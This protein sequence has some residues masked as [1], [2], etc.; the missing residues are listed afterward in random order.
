LIEFKDFVLSLIGMVTAQGQ[1][2][3]IPIVIRML[4]DF[5]PAT[6]DIRGLIHYDAGFRATLDAGENRILNSYDLQWWTGPKPKDLQVEVFNR[7]NLQR[8]MDHYRKQQADPGSQ[9][10]NLPAGAGTRRFEG[11]QGSGSVSRPGP[12]SGTHTSDV[13]ESES[14]FKAGHESACRNCGTY[15][16]LLSDV[17]QDVIKFQNFASVL[18]TTS[19]N[20]L[21]IGIRRASTFNLLHEA[22]ILK[23]TASTTPPAKDTK[24]KRIAAVLLNAS[25]ELKRLSDL[26]AS[27]YKW[28][29]G[30][31]LT[32]K[33]VLELRRT[34]TSPGEVAHSGYDISLPEGRQVGKDSAGPGTNLSSIGEVEDL[35]AEASMSPPF[36]DLRLPKYFKKKDYR[37]AYN[38]FQFLPSSSSAVLRT[39]SSSHDMGPDPENLTGNDPVESTEPIEAAPVHPDFQTILALADMWEEEDRVQSPGIEPGSIEFASERQGAGEQASESPGNGPVESAGIEPGSVAATLH[40]DFQTILT[41]AEMWETEEGESP[42]IKPGSVEF[43]SERRGA[44]E[45]T[46]ESPGN[47]PVESTGIAPGIVE[48][49]PLHPDF[50]TILAL[51]DMWETEEGDRVQS[52]GIEPG[53]IDFT[54]ER[55]GAGDQASESPGGPVV[56]TGIEPGSIEAAPLHPDFQ[57]ILALADMWETEEG[58]PVQSP[59]IK[60]GSVENPP[61]RQGA[62]EQASES[63]VESTGSVEAAPVHPD[64]QTILALA[65]IWETEDDFN[66]SQGVG[67][68]DLT[69][70][71][72]EHSGD[73]LVQASY[74]D[75]AALT[76]DQLSESDEPA[77]EDAESY[78]PGHFSFLRDDMFDDEDEDED[79]E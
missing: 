49:A 18:A 1:P 40:P 12:S 61:E 9:I 64:I 74:Q 2:L 57:T 27:S 28:T 66:V 59:G 46:S 45:Q 35:P 3:D 65:D 29:W 55:R 32:I 77:L 36:T 79:E 17:L 62:G 73:E 39:R 24:K 52:P 41:L 26:P 25:L 70:S 71:E 53:S 13:R 56:S 51:A 72:P 34:G 78:G 44:G 33:D 7:K 54:P 76:D 22:A 6:E 67:E 31:T 60:P 58:D 47:G 38:P 21:N 75:L 48:A 15:R 8:C 14:T 37:I 16:Q 23:E 43:V 11:N 50:Q 19:E 42:G 69:D 30:E 5:I 20:T 10:I 63:Q 4:I 68:Q